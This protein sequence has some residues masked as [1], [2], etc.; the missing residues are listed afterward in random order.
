M[1]DKSKAAR[2]PAPAGAPATAGD[3]NGSSPLLYSCLAARKG[4]AVSPDAL[5]LQNAFLPYH[6]SE[7][8]KGQID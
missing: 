1:V 3:A 7:C 4:L 2:S 8:P 6:S 5:S